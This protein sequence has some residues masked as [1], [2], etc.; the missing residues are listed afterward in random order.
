[1]PP[2]CLLSLTSRV[3]LDIRS[4]TYQPIVELL[5][6]HPSSSIVIDSSELPS[7]ILPVR[8][9][10][11]ALMIVDLSRRSLVVHVLE[12]WMGFETTHVGQKPPI[13]KGWN[14]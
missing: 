5:S 8:K 7:H 10:D 3:V 12:L 13:L 4:D 6:N 2:A 9:R 11:L 14:Q 1:M